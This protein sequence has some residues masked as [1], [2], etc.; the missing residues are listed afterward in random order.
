MTLLTAES[1]TVEA[2][3]MERLRLTSGAD[4]LPTGPTHQQPRQRQWDQ[5]EV[6]C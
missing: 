3:V 4:P 1:S 5:Y 6:C 2:A